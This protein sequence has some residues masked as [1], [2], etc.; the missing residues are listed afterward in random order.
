MD[1]GELFEL[2]ER[3]ADLDKMWWAA[4]ILVAGSLEAGEPLMTGSPAGDDLGYGPPLLASPAEV[5]R[6]AQAYESITFA[7]L[8]ARFDPA[9]MEAEHA[10]P[11]VWD[12]DREE[13]AT[14]VATAAMALLDLYRSA[15]A[16]GKSIVALIS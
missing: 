10:Y 5:A 11:N 14:E 16:D 15:A 6:V 9:A 2:L 7:E 13:L 1:P 3:G 4:Q 12:E 8:E